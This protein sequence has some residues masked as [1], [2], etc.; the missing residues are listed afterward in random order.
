MRQSRFSEEQI[1]GV[2]KEGGSGQGA[3]PRARDLRPDPLPVEGEVR[4]LGG[5]RGPPAAAVGRR[6]PAAEAD[7]GRAGAGHPG[8]ERGA[9]KKV[10][11]P[12]ARREAVGVRR[13][14]Y[15]RRE[16]RACQL[17]GRSRAAS[18][19]SWN[20][21][22]RRRTPPS[23]VSTASFGMNAGTRTGSPVGKRRGRR[24][25]PGGGITTRCARTGRW[26]IRPRRSSPPAPPREGP[27]PHA[28]GPLAR[29]VDFNPATHLMIGPQNGGGS[30]FTTL[31]PDG[32]MYAAEQIR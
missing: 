32:M 7:G 17:A 21:V 31:P 12:A 4:R 16:R 26:G 13:G 14:G 24:A 9:G 15:V 18:C 23:K 8:V 2:L 6:E 27:L 3:V 10:L 1:I 29:G 11:T 30:R 19:S 28:P 22:N 20:R 5:E 25:R